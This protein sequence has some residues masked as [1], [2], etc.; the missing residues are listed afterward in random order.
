MAGE[1]DLHVCGLVDLRV[2][3]RTTNGERVLHVFRFSILR[4]GFD[5]PL[6]LLVGA[7]A[8]DSPPVGI[9]H[10]P[11]IHGHYFPGLGVTVARKEAE[12]IQSKLLTVGCTFLAALAEAGTFSKAVGGSLWTG[13]ACG[14]QPLLQFARRT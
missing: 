6:F 5:K 8:L 12:A 14:Q 4:G 1:A 3:L 7:P 11:L 13:G 10:R 2:E 9:G